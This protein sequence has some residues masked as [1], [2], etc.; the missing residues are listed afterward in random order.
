MR[1]NTF[2]FL[3]LCLALTPV[4]LLADESN[5]REGAGVRISQLE[6][7]GQWIL[8]QDGTAV[9]PE[10]FRRGLQT[11]G[12]AVLGSSLLSVGDQRSQHPAA[13]LVID[14]KTARLTQSPIKIVAPVGGKN[15]AF[16]AYRKLPN[17][18]FEG[19]AVAPTKKTAASA[20]TAG[21]FLYAITEDKTPWIATIEYQPKEGQAKL[22]ALAELH[23]DRIS[24]TN[25]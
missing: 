12:F 14:P 23:C 1:T 5:A 2:L 15:E 25:A 7:R 13:L 9:G 8:R 22:A 16:S 17:P 10:S 20:V 6:V 4:A 24:A 21:H 18:D 19:I 11:S 3:G